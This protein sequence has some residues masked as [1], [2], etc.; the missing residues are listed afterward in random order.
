MAE[1]SGIARPRRTAHYMRNKRIMDNLSGYLFL[2]PAMAGYL[3]FIFGPIALSA[4]LSLFNYNLIQTP[5]FVGLGNFQRLFKDALAMNA[6][7][8]TFKFLAILVPIHCILGLILAFLVSRTRRLQGLYR[9][10]IYFPSIVTTASVTIA[11]A[12]IF[13]TDTGVINYFL[14]LLG[15]TNVK[16]LTDPTMAYVTIALFSFWKFIGTTF[17]YYYIG[18]KNIPETYY[19]AAQIDGASTVRIFFSVT[20]PLLTPTAFFVVVTNVIGVFQIFD[21]PFLLTSGGPGSATRTVAL[22]IYERAFL[23]TKIGYGAT[24]SFMLFLII[25]AVTILQFVG[26]RRWVNYDYE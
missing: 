14:R 22:E 11:W 5:S 13:S 2:A 8:N 12:Y 18:L 19:E 4:V 24:I 16:W 6:F 20:L 26:Q 25:L 23:Q 1:L 3:I 10:S 21:E 17:L 15:G 7:R 9:T